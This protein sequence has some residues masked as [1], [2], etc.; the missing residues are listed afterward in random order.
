METH[1]NVLLRHARVL[2]VTN[3]ILDDTDVLVV[4]GRIREIGKGL[5]APDGVT[6]LDLT[7]YWL[8]P[9]IVDPHS[10]MAVTGINEWTQSITCEVRQADVVNHTQLAVQRALAGGVTTIHTMH[11][12]ANTIGGQN[13]V[14]KLKFDTSPTEMLVTTGPRLV[15]FALGEN[16]TRARSTPR[17]PNSRMGVESVLRQAFNAALEYRSEERRVGKE[18]RL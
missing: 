5:A 7:G 3:G 17:F 12:S 9:G 10:H 11:G 1:G 18:C 2:T 13:A 14:L 15:K 4:G 16:V 6:P 8:S